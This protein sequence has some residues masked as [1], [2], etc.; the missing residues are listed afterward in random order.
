MT[1]LGVGWGRTFTFWIGAWIICF[2]GFFAAVSSWEVA[3][4]GGAVGAVV[5]LRATRMGVA[6]RAGEIVVRGFVTTEKVAGVVDVRAELCRW[7]QR[8]CLVVG[9]EAGDVVCTGLFWHPGLAALHVAADQPRRV[10]VDLERIAAG[11]GAAVRDPVGL[12]GS[13]GLR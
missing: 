13:P 1:R 12:A 11:C 5:V 9:S 2:S 10:A 3:A 7:R 8:L 6:V 4:V